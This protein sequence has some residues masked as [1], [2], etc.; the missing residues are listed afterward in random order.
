M[1]S[2]I[3]DESLSREY[4]EDL[5]RIDTAI[6]NFL[7]LQITE[8]HFYSGV[9]AK[10]VKSSFSHL[11]DRRQ[12]EDAAKRNEVKESGDHRE[13]EAEEQE[14]EAP[15]VADKLM[16][17]CGSVLRQCNSIT[18]A[19][20]V[21][22]FK[23]SPQGDSQ[24]GLDRL[25]EISAYKTKFNLWKHI[26]QS[27]E[28][29]T[30]RFGLKMLKQMWPEVRTRALEE[31]LQKELGTETQLNTVFEELAESWENEESELNELVWS[32]DFKQTLQQRKDARNKRVSER[33]ERLQQEQVLHPR[34]PGDD[35]VE[36]KEVEEN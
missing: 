1:G 16:R 32:K 28:K 31:C 3:I 22:Y 29:V 20:P 15:L 25:D 13:A 7:T 9:R 12:N 10:E 21:E 17:V 19:T 11:V 34:K 30:Q 26:R 14:C 8:K 27:N 35:K 6:R 24:T 33:V 36:I 5:P 4:I 23:D 2:Y 18:L